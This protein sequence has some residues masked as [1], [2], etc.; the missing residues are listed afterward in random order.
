MQSSISSAG[1]EFQGLAGCNQN[2][3]VQCSRRV[4]DYAHHF[5][6]VGPKN[7]AMA[8]CR[9]QTARVFERE[10]IT[11]QATQA[12]DIVFYINGI[13]LDSVTEFK[14]LDVL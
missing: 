10:R 12:K 14:Y 11:R 8:I 6:T 7:F 9:S 4:W 5:D 2:S 3:L 1:T 13:A